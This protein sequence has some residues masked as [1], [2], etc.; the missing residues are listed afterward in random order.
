MSVPRHIS[1]TIA[2]SGI[3]VPNAVWEKFPPEITQ[4]MDSTEK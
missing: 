3:S 1:S 2:T 4:G